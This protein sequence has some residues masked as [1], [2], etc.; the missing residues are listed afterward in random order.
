M[1]Q[2]LV[3]W[4]VAF[5]FLGWL[6][7]GQAVATCLLGAGI[8]GIWLWTG[9]GVLR[10]IVAQDIFFTMS[11]YSL[12][13]IP[14]YLLMAQMLMRGGVIVDIFRV[15][16]RLAGYKRFPLGVATLVTGGM[17]GGIGLRVGQCRGAGDACEPGT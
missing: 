13:I 7:L 8:V 2:D 16:H 17:L 9:P 4:I 5:W 14:L 6:I 1:P 11:T 15:G 12:S 3:V 10:G